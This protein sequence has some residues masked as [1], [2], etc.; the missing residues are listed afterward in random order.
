MG[1]VL[2]L[3]VSAY[4]FI[5]S[6]RLKYVY[7]LFVFLTPFLPK[8]IGFGVGGEGYALSLNRILIMILFMWAVISFTQNSAYISR[9]I[10]LVYQQNKLL[11]NLFLVFF[12]IK[13][14]SLTINSREF[15]LY[16][17]LFDDFLNT[18]FIFILTILIIDSEESID[19]LMKII[20]YGYIIALM[21]VYLDAFL[22]FPPLSVFSSGQIKN[23]EDVSQ[24]IMLGDK[25]RV[26]GS[27]TGPIDLGQYL[28]ILLPIVRVYINSHGYSLL[29]KTF[30]YISII[31]AI[32]STHSRSAILMFAIV[33]YLYFILRVYDSTKLTRFIVH[34][35]NLILFIIVFYFVFNY[36]NNLITNFTGSFYLIADEQ[37]RS[38]T[39]RALQY[40][41]V[42]EKMHEAPFF[43]FGRER[44]Y[45]ESLDLLTIDNLFF[46]RVLE[47]GL[48]GILT[49][50][51]F[52]YTTIK[53]TMNLYL[54]KHKCIYIEA[55]LINFICIVLYHFLSVSTV[56]H[57]YFY[58]FIGVVCVIN[59]LQKSE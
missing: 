4:F 17:M 40:I 18:I 11:I 5:I 42:Y 7:F 46:W 1:S 55:L 39:S 41:A 58:I 2:T 38:S 33:I 56:N 29:F 57:L 3:A 25:Y 30:F 54:N 9:R 15:T 37:V 34:I 50:L 28:V 16:I 35:F 6:Y 8:Y 12:L 49:Y 59:I 31:F 36:I 20:F 44:N 21:F 10:S 45:L 48:I 24:G 22:K 14:F 13:I 26:N 51:A 23:L 52:L 19:K 27:F 43:G 53:T 47:V 32:Y